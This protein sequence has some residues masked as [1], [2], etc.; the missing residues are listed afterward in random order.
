M[1]YLVL[2]ADLRVS[3]IGKSIYSVEVNRL[4]G[5]R[6]TKNS[7]VRFTDMTIAVYRGR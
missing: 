1:I 6:L 7:V 5:L 3:V 4:G 2:I